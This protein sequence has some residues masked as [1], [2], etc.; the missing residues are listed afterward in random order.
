MPSEKNWNPCF[1]VHDGNLFVLAKDMLCHSA[2]ANSIFALLKIS[3]SAGE[4]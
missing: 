1:W 3:I 4:E 2:S